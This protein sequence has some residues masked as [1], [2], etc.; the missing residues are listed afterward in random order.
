MEMRVLGRTGLHVSCLALGAGPVSGLMTGDDREL[1]QAVIDAAIAS[2]INWFDTA[3]GYGRGQSELCLGRALAGY[4]SDGTLHI[5]TKVRVP[6]DV[7]GSP[8]DVICRSVQESLL[9]LGRDHVT[10]LQLHNGITAQPGDEPDCVSPDQ[11][12]R[13]GGILDTMQGLRQEGIVKHLGLTG[14]GH[15]DSLRQ[16]IRSGQFDTIQIPFN[17]LNPSAGASLT[18]HDGRTNYGNLLAD[19]QAA[20]MGAF[21]I[22]V[23]A[24]GALLNQPPSAHTLTTRYFPLS[25]YEQDLQRA[26]DLSDSGLTDP[27]AMTQLAIRF[28][29]SHPVIT[30]SLIG[31]GH[32]DHVHELVESAIAGKLEP[33]LYERLAAFAVQ[34]RA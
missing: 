8:R 9:R 21:A 16:V 33:Q 2:G 25:L 28:V 10:L 27:I 30:A 14:T 31:F 11:I 22:R 19:C 12:F 15:A 5:A 23:L 7:S 29:L 13:A 18:F 32:L 24:G 6:L 1:Q 20:K 4:P 3:P 17:L 34:R 26:R